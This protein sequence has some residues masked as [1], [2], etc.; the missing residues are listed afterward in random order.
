MPHQTNARSLAE[1]G[2]KVWL[3]PEHGSSRNDIMLNP[4]ID[5]GPGGVMPALPV[6]GFAHQVLAALERMHY[7][8]DRVSH[9]WDR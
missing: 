3:T 9:P 1:A 2:I 7:H 8:C 5:L 6:G 4:H